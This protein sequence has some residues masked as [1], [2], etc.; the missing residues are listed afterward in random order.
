[1]QPGQSTNPDDYIGDFV[2]KQETGSTIDAS[3]VTVPS[4]AAKPFEYTANSNGFLENSDSDA[5]NTDDSSVT[6][7]FLFQVGINSAESSQI[8]LSTSFALSNLDKL[9]S[10][11]ESN[12]NYLET[13]D[14]IIASI[15]AKQ[16]EYGSAQNRLE[17]AI[18]EISIHYENLISS[19][20][21]I[22]DADIA[23]ESSA[24]I[25]NQ[26]LQ[27]AASTLLATA[28]QTPGIALQLI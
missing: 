21:T 25:R 18:D 17:S 11:G 24:Y 15:S 14:K 8:T 16:T 1:M 12:D 2:G 20:S 5:A 28:N 13:I 27:Q 10:I 4:G 22:R 3:C 7:K 23:Q 9:R 6:A 26:I 19:N